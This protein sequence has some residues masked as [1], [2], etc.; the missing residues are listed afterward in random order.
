[1]PK[2]LNTPQVATK[3]DVKIIENRLDSSFKKVDARFERIDARFEDLEERIDARFETVDKK[4]DKIANTLDGFVGVVDNLRIENEV[5][6]HQIK[7][8]DERVTKLESP[9]A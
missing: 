3:A 4:L 8:L 6:A 5:G 7:E 2:K 1:M 9:S